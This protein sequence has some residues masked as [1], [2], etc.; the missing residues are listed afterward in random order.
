M[1]VIAYFENNSKNHIIALTD[2]NVLQYFVK[3]NGKIKTELSKNETEIFKKVIDS[4]KVSKETSI[5]LGIQYWKNELFRLFYDKHT[6][7]YYTNNDNAEI[8]SYINFKYNNVPDIYCEEYKQPNENGE[9]ATSKNKFLKI[10]IRIGKKIITV[11]LA[12]TISLSFLSACNSLDKYDDENLITIT[13]M[14]EDELK[15]L[16]E[17][18]KN[19]TDSNIK[20]ENALVAIESEQEEQPYDYFEIERAIDNNE[21]LTNEEKDFIKK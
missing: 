17:G 15:E 18:L 8:I 6:C 3:N 1:E 12:A 7:L 9:K 2:N 4:I 11:F 20:Q 21:N 19:E 5:D 16:N 13:E 10:P 14:S